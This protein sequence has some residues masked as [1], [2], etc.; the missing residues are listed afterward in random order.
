MNKK[1]YSEKR[2]SRVIA[3]YIVGIFFFLFLFAISP[4]HALGIAPSR[5]ILQ[6]DTNPHTYTVRI[7]NNEYR[8]MHLLLYAQGELAPYIN[9]PETTLYIGANEGEK[10]FTY[11]ITLPQSIEPGERSASI[12]AIEA[13][14]SKA[15]DTG[16]T[17]TSTISVAHQLKVQVPYP[18]TFASGTF[19]ISES[20]VNETT[21]FNLN[22]INKGTG[23]IK[24]VTSELLIRGPTNEIIRRIPGPTAADILTQQSE[25]LTINWL[26]N[27]NPGV[28]YAEFIVNYDGKQ[29]IERKTFMVGNYAIDIAEL[30]VNDFKLGTIAKFNIDLVNS[31]NEPI[32]NVY[33]ELQII[34]DKMQVITTTKTISTTITQQST[35]SIYAYWDTQGIPAGNYD[36]RI[37]LHYAGKTS[38]RIYKAVVGIDAISIQDT[39]AT[40]NVL[41]QKTGGSSTSVLTVLVIILVVIN[42]GWFIYFKFL[43]KKK[44]EK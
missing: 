15:T 43:K 33:A 28:Y 1:N 5:E 36:V 40:G 29:F 23:M 22:I 18:G 37:I 21:T 11:T 39:Q 13:P 31:W 32:D 34:D 41:A 24:E 7:I 6:Y 20:N 10:A 35:T 8:E 4:I 42:A 9:L 12:F 19:Y 16:A 2:K 17:I 38:E 14:E 30:R 25:K 27:T 44:T 26:A 3:L